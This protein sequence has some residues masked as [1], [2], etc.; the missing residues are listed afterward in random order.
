MTSPI[1]AGKRDVKLSPEQ[2]DPDFTKMIPSEIALKIL[3]FY[4]V[5]I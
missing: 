5:L 4:H 2:K 1:L 3:S